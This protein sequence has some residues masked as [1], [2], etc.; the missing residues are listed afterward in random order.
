MKIAAGERAAARRDLEAKAP[1]TPGVILAV[2]A[3]EP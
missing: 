2:N 3:T 1:G